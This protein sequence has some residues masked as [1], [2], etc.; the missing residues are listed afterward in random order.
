[1]ESFTGMM[2]SD[3]SP[4]GARRVWCVVDHRSVV[5]VRLGSTSV[6]MGGIRPILRPRTA[7]RPQE[8]PFQPPT[9]PGDM[10]IFSRFFY[11]LFGDRPWIPLIVQVVLNA[12]MPALTYRVAR[13]LFDERV[14][15]RCRFARPDS[16][17]SI[18][19]TRPR[20]PLMRFATCS[21]WRRCSSLYVPVQRDNSAL[22]AA[23][24]RSFGIA[25]QFRPNLILIPLLL[26]LFIAPSKR[27]RLRACATGRSGC[28]RL[29]TDARALGGAE[30]IA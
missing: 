4:D 7:S 18:R 23:P 8:N 30:I 9:C 22:F 1:M 27:D 16:C 5:R 28:R 3:E 24:E 19:C 13:Q 12:L 29:C 15:D 17:R 26:A 2:S 11:R 6:G 10:R 20:S 14:G 25:P 21:S